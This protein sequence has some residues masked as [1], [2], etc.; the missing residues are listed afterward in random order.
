MHAIRIT[1]R[2]RP[3]GHVRAQMIKARGGSVVG[4]VSRAEKVTVARDAGGSAGQHLAEL[5]G[6]GRSRARP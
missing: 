4:L 2:G 3:G 6:R 5:P 1:Q